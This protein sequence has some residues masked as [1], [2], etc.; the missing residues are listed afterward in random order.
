MIWQFEDLV[1]LIKRQK[2]TTEDT[3]V[4]PFIVSWGYV[5]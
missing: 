5:S 4:M 2:S 1:I 3:E